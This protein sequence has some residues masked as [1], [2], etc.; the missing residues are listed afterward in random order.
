[1]MGWAITFLVVA[2]IAAVLGFGGIAGVAIEAAKLVFFVAIIL[3][4]VSAV[5]HLVRGRSST[6]L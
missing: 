4:L 5:I 1:M 2:L 6:A 3:F